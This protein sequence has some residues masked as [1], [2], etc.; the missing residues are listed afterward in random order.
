MVHGDKDMHGTDQQ[1]N[2]D[3]LARARTL[4]NLRR[5]GRVLRADAACEERACEDAMF[6]NACPGARVLR[7]H[8]L[9]HVTVLVPDVGAE[10]L[11]Q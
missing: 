2:D 8:V 6:K 10:E 5:R 9:P 3:R 4:E 11:R 1:S 7:E